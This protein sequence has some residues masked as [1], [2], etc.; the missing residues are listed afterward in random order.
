MQIICV[1]NIL[2]PA[3]IDKVAARVPA[4]FPAKVADRIFS[5]LRMSAERLAAMSA[6]R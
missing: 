2:T 4:D 3:V 1:A 5:G 6:K